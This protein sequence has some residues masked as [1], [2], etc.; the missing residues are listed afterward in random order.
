M[1]EIFNKE[2]EDNWVTTGQ[3]FTTSN[4]NLNTRPTLNN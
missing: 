2:I 3:F 4:R 1:S